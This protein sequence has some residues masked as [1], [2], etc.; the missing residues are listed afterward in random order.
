MQPNFIPVS[1]PSISQLEIDYVNEA[2]SSGW[3]SS[4]GK[5]VELFEGDF[6]TFCGVSEALT[7]SNGTVALHL[8]MA[9]LGIGPGD[10]VIVPDLSFVATANAVLH[11]GATPVFADIDPV[12][13]CL[14]PASFKSKITSRTKAVIPV[15]LY[16]HPADMDAI[17]AIADD[18][19]IFV[20]EDAAEAHGAELKGRRVGSMGICGTFSFY[21]NKNMTTGEGGMI[22][23]NDSQFAEKCRYLRDHAMDPSKRYWHT[24]PGFNYRLTNIQAALGCAQLDRLPQFL[25]RRR[26]I[27]LAYEESLRDY[28]KV[29][30]NRTL[31]GASNSYWI[32][33]AEIADIDSGIRDEVI[34]GLKARGVDSRPY[35]YPMSDM[36]YFKRANTPVSH[37]VAQRGL[38]LPTYTDLTDSQIAYVSKCLIEAVEEATLNL[39]PVADGL[40]VSE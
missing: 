18:H 11:A 37:R 6:A 34:A 36:P 16:G 30:L 10:E 21:G 28:P 25:A 9:A 32:I 29:Q 14:C 31:P 38:N 35:F 4:L 20:I 23:S 8:A 13:L 2:V 22:T 19:E 1:M 40:A 5:F 3:V 33:C 26:E 24:E 12:S 39:H 27:F 17:C 7:V 15:H